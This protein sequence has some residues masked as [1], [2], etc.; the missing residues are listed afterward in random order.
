MLWTSASPKESALPQHRKIPVI[1]LIRFVSRLTS[2][3]RLQRERILQIRTVTAIAAAADAAVSSLHNIWG[4][5]V[6][7]PLVLFNIYYVKQEIDYIYHIFNIVA[8][9]N[10]I[11]A[12][13]DNGF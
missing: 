6:P 7:Q 12:F 13:L 3:S 1:Y 10:I 2:F 11:S 8:S 4:C 5:G 9:H